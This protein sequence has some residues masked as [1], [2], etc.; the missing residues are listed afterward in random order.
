MIALFLLASIES[1]SAQSC[2]GTATACPSPTYNNLTVGASLSAA[3]AV[4]GAGFT[5]LL[6]PYVTLTGLTSTLASPPP[7]GSIAP[8]SG[9][10]TDLISAGTANAI[11]MLGN[12]TGNPVRILSQGV[13]TN[14]G[15]N[16]VAQ[17]AASVIFSAQSGNN[18]T[19]QIY[20]G[21]TSSNSFIATVPG[22]AA[23]QMMQLFT[24]GAANNLLLGGPLNG[25]TLSTTATSQFPAMPYTPGIPTGTPVNSTSGAVFETNSTSKT[26]NIYV[27]GVGWYHAALT[28][29]AG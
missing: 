20:S 25:G 2:P 6:S 16:V 18:P 19:F 11:R 7:I 3:G 5:A 21:N 9:A 1:A 24:N 13:D 8:N 12:T 29:G 10:F 26:L 14:I 15:I 17:G 4:S 23:S 28:A 22:I 27:P